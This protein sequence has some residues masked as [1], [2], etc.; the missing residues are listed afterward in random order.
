MDENTQTPIM[1]GCVSLL[2][3]GVIFMILGIVTMVLLL[4]FV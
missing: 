2:V 3:V 4:T 1:I